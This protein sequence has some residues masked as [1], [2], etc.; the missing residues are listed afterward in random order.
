MKKSLTSDAIA[1]ILSIKEG[2]AIL[3]TPLA[4]EQ[5]SD[6]IEHIRVYTTIPK[7]SP[8]R[9]E[10]E[11]EFRKCNRISFDDVLGI[12]D[13]KIE[14][15][16]ANSYMENTTMNC[17]GAIKRNYKCFV[18]KNWKENNI[19][20]NPMHQDGSCSWNCLMT[21]LH[22]P[23]YGIV[24]TVPVDSLAKFNAINAT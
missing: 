19:T 24:Y 17:S 22:H 16:L 6:L 1:E 13:T 4:Q 2:K 12:G 10:L 18:F 23:K 20:N 3:F 15:R 8:K 5:F 9:K 11:T 14:T 7:Q 21:K